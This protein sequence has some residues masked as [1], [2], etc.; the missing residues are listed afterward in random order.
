MLSLE[1]ALEDLSNE[2]RMK[3]LFKFFAKF[4]VENHASELTQYRCV[5]HYFPSNRLLDIFFSLPVQNY[6]PHPSI[7]AI[8]LVWES[9]RMPAMYTDVCITKDACNVHWCMHHKGWLQ[10]TRLF[11]AQNSIHIVVRLVL[12]VPLRLANY[13]L[14]QL[15]KFFIYMPQ[16]WPLCRDTINTLDLRQPFRWYPIARS[17]QRRIIYHAV[18]TNSGKTY[19]ALQVVC[20]A[21][22]PLNASSP[23]F[24]LNLAVGQ[25]RSPLSRI[26]RSQDLTPLYSLLELRDCRPRS[27]QD[28]N[29][30]EWASLPLPFAV[31]ACCIACSQSMKSCLSMRGQCS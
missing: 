13:V 26:P 2:K 4:V 6:A 17:L 30:H 12:D 22:L 5:I 10:E 7:T 20:F 16:D 21:L 14:P 29:P 27:L 11:N 23:G 15:R 18:P 24:F 31:A 1:A 8:L 3:Y 28:Q 25:S 19:T 9:S